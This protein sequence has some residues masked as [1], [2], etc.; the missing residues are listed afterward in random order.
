MATQPTTNISNFVRQMQ[1]S[2]NGLTR[3][4]A[5]IT[6]LKTRGQG[7][8]CVALW[9]DLLAMMI[10]KRITRS[11]NFQ[12]CPYFIQTNMRSFEN[13]IGRFDFRTIP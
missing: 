8:A 10:H 13:Q 7:E 11:E 2:K 4:C 12:K 9:L 6:G 5:Q 3:D 1:L